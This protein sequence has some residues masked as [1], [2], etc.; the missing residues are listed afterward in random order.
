[1][2]ASLDERAFTADDPGS[3]S[4]LLAIGKCQQVAR[5]NSQAVVIGSDQIGWCD[6]RR[7]DK[8]GSPEGACAQLRACQGKT[9]VFFTSVCVTWPGLD[10]PRTATVQTAL[11][12]RSLSD[13]EIARYVELD[14]PID[15]AGSFKIEA[16]GSHLFE[17][18]TSDDPSALIGLP[19]LA[20]LAFLREAGIDPLKASAQTI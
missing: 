8:P 13:R 19:M 2:P 10:E 20:T 4:E 9:A 3:L 5:E 6:N 18:V 12:F 7:L 17:Y 11:K 1:M 14:K 16:N 15:C